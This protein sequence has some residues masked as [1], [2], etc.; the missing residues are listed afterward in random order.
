MKNL[1]IEGTKEWDEK[2]GGVTIEFSFHKNKIQEF[3]FLA[4][5]IKPKNGTWKWYYCKT[6]KEYN[7]KNFVHAEIVRNE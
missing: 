2:N 6:C 5:K 4:S 3:E 1:I 7:G